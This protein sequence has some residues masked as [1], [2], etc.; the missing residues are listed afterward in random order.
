MPPVKCFGMEL[1]QHIIAAGLTLSELRRRM[2][3]INYR[4][5]INHISDITR[6]ERMPTPDFIR[7]VARVLELDKDTVRRMHRAAC[8]DKG[9]DI[10][11]L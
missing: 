11:A 9:F 10:G 8:L 1:T 3:K 2:N 4:V 7:A 6:S 5:S